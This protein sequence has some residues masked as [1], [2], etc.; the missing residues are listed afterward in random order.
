MSASVWA[1]ANVLREFM[2]QRVYLLEERQE[3]AE[4]AKRVVR[5]LYA[6]FAERPEEIRSEFVIE[7]DPAW[8]RAADYVAGMT[9]RYALDTAARLEESA[10]P[11]RRGAV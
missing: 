8:R 9:D 11:A 3:E 4:R 1:A 6:Y 7:S 10:K 2:F 5:R